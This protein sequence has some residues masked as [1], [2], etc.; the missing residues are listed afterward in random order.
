MSLV[1]AN[2]VLRYLL[3]DHEELSPKAADILERHAVTW[4]VPTLQRG[5]ALF[6]RSSGQYAPLERCWLRS[7]A[8]A[9]ERSNDPIFQR[10]DLVQ[11]HEP[12]PIRDP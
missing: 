3:D 5:N 6:G 10:L 12:K 8:G 1:D 7:H 4:I 2:V 9:W 11:N